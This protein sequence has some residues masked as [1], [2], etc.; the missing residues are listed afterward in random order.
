MI[1]GLS[2]DADNNNKVKVL[3][4]FPLGFDFL[5]HYLVDEWMPKSNLIS[6]LKPS[7]MSWI[8]HQTICLTLN[9]QKYLMVERKSSNQM[10][11]WLIN[12]E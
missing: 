9:R 11:E 10:N 2:D 5:T 6:N 12:C 1:K 4:Q 3:V 8:I 7:T